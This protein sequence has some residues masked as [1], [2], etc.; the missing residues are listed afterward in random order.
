MVFL[1]KFNIKYL[2]IIIAVI[3]S[4][5]G[6]QFI[7]N[8]KT[9]LII[10]GKVII[11]LKPFIL[12]SIIAYV[13]NP[14]MKLFERRINLNRMFS[15]LLTYIVLISLIIIFSMVVLPK[16][17]NSGMDM[18]NSIPHYT[19]VVYNWIN[20][21]MSNKIINS[22]GFIKDNANK[23][24]Q[25]IG[26]ISSSWLTI[27]LSRV[28]DTTSS[29]INLI[30]GLIISI[31][32]LFDKEKFKKV[33][34]DFIYIIFRK[35]I[36]IT[37]INFVKTVN[38]MVTL[39]LGVKA[40]DSIIIGVIACI[41]LMIFKS[42][43]VLIVSIIITVT[44]MIPYFGPF[45]GMLPPFVIN[46]FYSPKRAIGVLIF[47]ILLQQFD[48]WILEPKLVGNKMSISP[49][50]IILGITIFGNLFGVWGMLLAS[51]IMA[52]LNVYIGKWFKD[53]AQIYNS[54]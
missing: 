38:N 34:T 18:V 6:I 52:V 23:V 25:K 2:D 26:E 7:M 30:F 49:F 4:F 36:G 45:I 50:L 16:I 5:L 48:A 22:P 29:L 12:A 19:Q 40:I 44:N 32:I 31:Y 11:I 1:K 15:I 53:K 27:V 21:H 39:Y 51:P 43:Y 28:I 20:E 37:I 35:K 24:I 47:L 54:K 10:L 8:Y 41:G 42:P 33:S 13:L 46:L 3:I 14:I 17:F 9:F